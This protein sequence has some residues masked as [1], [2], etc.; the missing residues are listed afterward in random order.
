[1]FLTFIRVKSDMARGCERAKEKLEVQPEAKIIG[2]YHPIGVEYSCVAITEAPN[3][4]NWLKVI[5]PKLHGLPGVEVMKTIT[6]V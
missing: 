1:M 5:A 4:E 3:F 6:C 2:I